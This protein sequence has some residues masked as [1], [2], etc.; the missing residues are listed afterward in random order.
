MWL[1]L[2]TQHHDWWFST[3]GNIDK[4]HRDIFHDFRM[5]TCVQANF[6][7]LSFLYSLPLSFPVS[8]DSW[9]TSGPVSRAQLLCM[10]PGG[11]EWGKRWKRMHMVSPSVCLSAQSFNY[12]CF[13]LISY[14]FFTSLLLCFA[15]CW[16][17]LR[18]LY[19][20]C[21]CLFVCLFIGLCILT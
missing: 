21:I 5:W 7:H 12:C 8:W 2:S 1:D 6:M 18:L 15:C 20:F 14:H 3:F 9:G 13:I 4:Y 17:V 19:V 10:W 11:Q 16:P